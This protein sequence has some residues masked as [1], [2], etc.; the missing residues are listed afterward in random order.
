MTNPVRPLDPRSLR[1]NPSIEEAP[2]QGEL[3]LF[4]PSTGQ[5][6]VMNRTMA[7]AWRQ[8]DGKNSIAAMAEEIAESFEGV[9][10][11]QAEFDVTRAVEELF[12]LGLLVDTPSEIP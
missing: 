9:D 7:T 5:F 11:R 1:R 4:N 6:F 2:L 8:C 12:N 3:M 10:R